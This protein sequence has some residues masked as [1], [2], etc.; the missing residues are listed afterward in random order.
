MELKDKIAVV[1]GGASVIGEALCRR[2]HEEGSKG[3]VVVD[4][5]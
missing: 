4:I 1:T 2:F 5:N 3:V